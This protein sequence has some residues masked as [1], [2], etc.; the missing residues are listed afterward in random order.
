L[1]GAEPNGE[2]DKRK[3]RQDGHYR[4]QNGED[5][6]QNTNFIFHLFLLAG[7]FPHAIGRTA[8]ARGRLQ[9]FTNRATG[10]KMQPERA[11][12]GLTCRRGTT[13]E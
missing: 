12:A 9:N 2:G 10:E 5:R 8:G 7:V 13:P 6:D 3:H 11:R 1:P 4:N